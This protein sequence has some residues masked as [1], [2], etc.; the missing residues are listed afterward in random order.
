MATGTENISGGGIFFL[1]LLKKISP[2]IKKFSPI[3]CKGKL[4]VTDKGKRPLQFEGV[5]CATNLIYVFQF[6]LVDFSMDNIF[7]SRIVIFCLALSTT[8]I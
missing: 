1:H 4:N 3:A 6:F 5:D 2:N 8:P 7:Y